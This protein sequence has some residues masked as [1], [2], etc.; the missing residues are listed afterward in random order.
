[1]RGVDRG[2]LVVHGR[3]FVERRGENPRQRVPEPAGGHVD[4][5]ARRGR[6]LQETIH[7][8][9]EPRPRVVLPLPPRG[10]LLPERGREGGGGGEEE[11]EGGGGSTSGRASGS[12]L[13]SEQRQVAE[14]ADE[15]GAKDELL[16]RRL[17][18]ERGEGGGEE[19]GGGARRGDCEGGICNN[20]VEE[21][22]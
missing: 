20:V 12:E 15:S 4:V 5:E 6:R 19:G 11:E 14:E 22:H 21:G 16:R 18:E 9:L 1:M 10:T 13:E 3:G 17:V 7:A 8:T 2:P